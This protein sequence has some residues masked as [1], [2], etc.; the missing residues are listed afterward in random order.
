[1]LGALASQVKFAQMAN[2]KLKE[3]DQEHNR[4]IAQMDLYFQGYSHDYRVKNGDKFQLK[5]FVNR[6][7]Q[8]T[9]REQLS[10]EIESCVTIPSRIAERQRFS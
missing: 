10:F 5:E 9:G 7:G 3:V 1:M 8:S 6:Q 4:F 2:E